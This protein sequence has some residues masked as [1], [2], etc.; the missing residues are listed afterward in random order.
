MRLARLAVLDE[1]DAAQQS[2]AAHVA[3]F[4]VAL[5]QFAQAGGEVIA[6]FAAALEE[7]FLHDRLQHGEAHRRRQRV[8][9]VR[10]VER[11]ASLVT[12]LLDFIAVSYTHLT[13]P[14]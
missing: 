5:L 11:E 8:G 4:R 2:H 14:T 6:H 7:L 13:L 10:R 1:L 9:Y 12:A 3:D